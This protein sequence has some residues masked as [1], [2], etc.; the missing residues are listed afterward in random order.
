MTSFFALGLHAND[1]DRL[2]YFDIE[3]SACLGSAQLGQLKNKNSEKRL[4]TLPKLNG[5]G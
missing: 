3:I 4:P 1:A 5:L 2:H